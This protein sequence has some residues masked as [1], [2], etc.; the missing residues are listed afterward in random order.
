MVFVAYVTRQDPLETTIVGTYANETSQMYKELYD[1]LTEYTH[2]LDIDEAQDYIRDISTENDHDRYKR[3]SYLY[4]MMYM[5]HCENM[6]QEEFEEAVE[7]FGDT[8]CD[9]TWTWDIIEK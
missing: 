6:T 5:N 2:V 9:Q 8:Y 3:V 1:K 7:T 4:D